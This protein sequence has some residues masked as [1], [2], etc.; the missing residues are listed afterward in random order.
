MTI[1]SDFSMKQH[2]TLN[3][4][5]I[6][7]K[8]LQKII[9]ERIPYQPNTIKQ[10]YAHLSVADHAFIA[11]LIFG[12]LRWYFLLEPL[13][14]RQMQKPLKAKDH[15]V[16]LLLMIG[17]YQIHFLKT[18]PHA[19]VNESVNAVSV[20][21]K[22]WAKGLV[23]AVLKKLALQPLDLNASTVDVQTAHPK[24][25]TG[26]LEKQWGIESA[27]QILHNNN[28]RAPLTLRIHQQ[29]ISVD[30]YMGL[31]MQAGIAAERCR[32]APFGITLESSVAVPSLPGYLEGLFS[33]QDQ[34]AQLVAPLLE[35]QNG[36]VVLDAC[37]APGGKTTHL[38]ELSNQ[39]ITLY[40]VEKNPNKIAL[41]QENLNRLGLQCQT[42]CADAATLGQTHTLPQFD[43]ILLDAPCSGTGIIR[44]HPDIKLL[45]QPEDIQSLREQQ[46]LLLHR[47]WPLLKPGGIFVY[48]TCSILKSENEKQ[49]IEFLSTTPDAIDYPIATDWG[50]SLTCGR[51]L[52]TGMDDNMD[53]FYYARFK[54][55]D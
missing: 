34:S 27:Q 32:Y 53:G 41:I 42:I 33:V 18:P 30:N 22:A 23:N 11:N 43:R 28:Q 13:I 50:N 25:L 10:H 20:I 51:Q 36:H 44:R 6:A 1:N 16:K 14:N 40:A 52:L 54:K 29:K 3:Q 55:A 9:D 24:W 37:S 47:L 12:V 21:N 17:L 4:R 46:H 31:L 7:C 19:A 26:M 5:A 38:L 2:T 49:A 45:R 15:D 35:V 39:E 8:L 48:S